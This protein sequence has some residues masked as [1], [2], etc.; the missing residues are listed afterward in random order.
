MH[1][2]TYDTRKCMQLLYAFMHAH[3]IVCRSTDNNSVIIISKSLCVIRLS[4]V[5]II[6]LSVIII[7]KILRMMIMPKP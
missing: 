3:I 5:I 1:I 7:S 4:D 2:Y 6:R